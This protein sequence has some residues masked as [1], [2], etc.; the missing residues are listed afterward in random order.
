MKNWTINK[1]T[2]LLSVLVLSCSKDYIEEEV[3]L[4]NSTP[5][6]EVQTI[7]PTVVVPET[8]SYSTLSERYSSINET[9]GY[10]KS[11]EFVSEYLTNEEIESFT[12]HDGGENGYRRYRV[13]GPSLVIADFDND[14]KPDVFGFGNSFCPDH[15]WSYHPG[16]FIFISDYKGSKIKSVYDSTFHFGVAM[17]VNDFNG[18]GKVEVLVSSHDTKMN[19][20]LAEED[21]GG[22]GNVKNSKPIIVEFNGAFINQIE[23][24]T[25]Q[26]T[27]AITSGDVNNDGLVD[28]I[29]FPIQ[30]FY[31]GEWN[32]YYNKP[33]VSINTGNFN[34]TTED[35]ILDLNFDSWFSTAYEVFD[36]NGDSYLDVVAGWEI[37]AEREEGF[38]NEF[39][40]NINGPIILWGDGSGNYTISNST[41]LAEQ[42]LSAMDYHSCILGFGFSDYDSDGDIDI[43]VTT[44]REEPDGSFEQGNY[45][46]SYFVLSFQN[47]GNKILTENSNII[48]NGFN[49]QE[50]FTNFYT[51]KSLDIN[52]DGKFDIIPFSIPNWGDDQYTDNLHW[53]NTG[54]NYEK[55]W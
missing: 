53:K 52:E 44:T 49:A 33:T 41:E 34:F 28:F 13:F 32:P 15:P 21:L 1:Y 25:D 46:K 31:D 23:V 45:Y 14:N 55:S 10:F 51:I 24:G 37:G 4:S 11:Q 39:N 19:S 8:I 38:D 27:H 17:S 50:A 40:F 2:F 22:W 6:L 29:Q 9:T 54:N 3:Y 35:L 30:G 5:T 18:D 20:Y 7:T 36:V 42:S 47:S 43:L 12:Y 16:K 26:D 48:G